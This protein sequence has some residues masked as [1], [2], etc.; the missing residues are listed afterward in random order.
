[1]ARE[2]D[3]LGPLGQFH[4]SNQIEGKTGQHHGL[5]T[6]R[7]CLGP[8]RQRQPGFAAEIDLLVGIE[9]PLAQGVGL[10]A[11]DQMRRAAG[12]KAHHR[13]IAGVARAGIADDGELARLIVEQGVE[14]ADHD[15]VEIEEQHVA[16]E[17]DARRPKRELAPGAAAEPARRQPNG[18]DLARLDP[19]IEAGGIVGESD[20]PGRPR[21]MA[22][23]AAIELVDVFDRKTV[24]PAHTDY[25]L[26]SR[27]I[28]GGRAAR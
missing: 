16:F 15:D 2:H 26:H 19:G 5:K 28:M 4:T 27:A 3:D 22:H 25:R 6:G 9:P 23:D 10:E 14:P 17:P 21:D 7:P 11:V 12:G 8:E 24:A 1:M 13:G 20:K 18:R